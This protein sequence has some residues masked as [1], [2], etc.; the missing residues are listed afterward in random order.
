MSPSSLGA[1]PPSDA[2]CSQ[3]SCRRRLGV[4][5][6]KITQK[7]KTNYLEHL[8]T[9]MPSPNG[10]F[11]MD[12]S[13]GPSPVLRTLVVIM[14]WQLG[15]FM[16]HVDCFTISMISSSVSML[17]QRIRC[18]SS[19]LWTVSQFARSGMKAPIEMVVLDKEGDTIQCTVKDIFV[20]IFDG[21]LAEGNMYVVTNFGVALNTIKFKPTRHEFRIHFKRDTIVRPVQDSS[22]PLNGFNFVPFKTIQSEFKED[23]YLVD[24]IGQLASKGNLVEFTRDGKPGGQKLRVTLWQSFAFELLKYLEEHPCLTY[25]VILQMDKMKFYSGLFICLFYWY[26]NACF[27]S[28]YAYGVMGVSNTNYNSKLFINVEFPA[29]KNFFANPVDGQGIM[30]LVCDQPVSDEEDFLRLSVYK[31]IAEIKEHNQPGQLKKLRLNLVGGTKDVRSVVIFCPNCI[32]DYEFYEPRYNIHIRVIDHT[33]AASFVLF[34]GEAA[35]FLGV[36]ANDLRQ[37]CVTKG[38]GK[39]SCPEEINKLRDIKFIFK[40]NYSYADVKLHNN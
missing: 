11:P 8:H 25:V 26:L 32:R 33:D 37:S 27:V 24:V 9:N 3:S 31:T 5:V 28:S 1:H 35:K 4:I 13:L 7:K 17:V 6:S 29:A 12:P 36:S 19:K 20:P 18:E 39:N 22:V 14:Q 10:S 38:V 40:K 23:G 2:S 30:P 21:L 34:D 16:C 15:E